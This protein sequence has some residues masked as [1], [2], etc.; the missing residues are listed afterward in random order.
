VPAPEA[1]LAALEEVR[2]PE[3][4]LSVVE[5]G[6]VYGVAVDRGR[7]HVTMTLTAAGCP[8]HAVMADWVRRAAG[9]VPGVEHVD[10]TVTF[11]PPWTPE[12]IRPRRPAPPTP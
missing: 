7:V 2:D 8:L 4:G 6:L 5:L 11:E 12:R 3:V 10:V 9:R 1:I